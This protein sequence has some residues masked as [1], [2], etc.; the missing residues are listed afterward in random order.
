MKL[1]VDDY[2]VRTGAVKGD[3]ENLPRVEA[4]PTLAR[5]AL[6][7]LPGRI[8]ETIDPYTEADP[9]ATLV[10][11]LVGVGNLIGPVAHACVQHDRHPGRLNALLV[12]RTGKGRKG[13]SWSTLRH[14]LG[15]LDDEWARFRVKTGLSSGE[16][17]IYNVRDARS[18]KQPIREKGRVVGYE[19]V[20][21]DE[22]EEDKRLLII[23]P[24]FAVTLRVIARE[25]N[26]LSG[27]LR[28]AWDSGDLATLT[29]NSPLRATSAHISII[30][31]ITVEEIRRYLTETER[32]NG[33]A[34]RFLFCLV[35]RSKCLPESE[36]VPDGK[37][38]PLVKELREVV[39]FAAALEGEIA[40]DEAAR[41]VWAE[42][43]PALSEETP[44]L[45][46]AILNRAEAQVLRLSVLYA[47]LDRSRVIKP[48]HL[49]AALALWDYAEASA[50][51]IFAERLGAPVADLILEHLRTQ[52]P[53]TE[54]V[55]SALFGR[56]KPAAEIQAALNYLENLRKARSHEV[57]TEG[58][59]ATVWEA[60]G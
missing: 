3:L 48:D 42:V 28:Q 1:G 19:D 12:G 59:S 55:I 22:G 30:G 23:E 52:G 21:L 4:W 7:G 17:L 13:T 44:G 40:R 37:L 16:G 49:K 24:E 41:A 32:A 5:E 6:Y 31:H 53:M 14:L 15:Q 27:I 60:V 20:R 58:R 50:R 29:K 34:N 47:V 26:T 2:I 54:T 43:Y 11:T 10:H 38:A 56:H 18:E 35:R 51:R 57:Q 36:P 45:V 46:G 39:A 8:V 33:F 25:N 9:V